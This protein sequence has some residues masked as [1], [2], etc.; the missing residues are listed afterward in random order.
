MEFSLY[1]WIKILH[2]SCAAISI[3]GFTVRGLLKLTRPPSLQK[4]WLRIAPHINDSILLACAIYLTLEIQQ[5]PGS[6]HWLT[7]KVLGLFAYILL[8]MVVMRFA[9]TQRQRLIALLAALLCFCYI[10]AVALTR[11]PW[12]VFR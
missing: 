11:N 4:R 1:Y 10:A 12:I 6:A 7:A 3:C 9:N 8:G 2:I 5:F